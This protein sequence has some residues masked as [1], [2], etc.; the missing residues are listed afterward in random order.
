MFV[1][2]PVM[3]VGIVGVCATVYFLVGVYMMR[4]HHS[5][6]VY[7]RYVDQAIKQGLSPEDAARAVS[8]H[9]ILENYMWPKIKWDTN[10]KYKF[11]K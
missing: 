2:E 11:K 1:P 6:V 3:W 8:M 9:F 7:N 10:W 4:H 5:D